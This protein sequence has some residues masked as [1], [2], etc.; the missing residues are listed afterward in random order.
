MTYRQSESDHGIPKNE[1]DGQ[2]TSVL[3]V[4]Y[5]REG[6]KGT[7]YSQK[8]DWSLHNGTSKSVIQFQDLSQL[9]NP[10]LPDRREAGSP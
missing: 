9:T 10:Q 3:L 2:S 4:L 6:K 1:L 7:I 8:H 5:N